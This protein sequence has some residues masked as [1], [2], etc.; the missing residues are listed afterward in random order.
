MQLVFPPPADEQC[1]HT[2]CIVVDIQVSEEVV[3]V[4]V[5]GLRWKVKGKGH[6]VEGIRHEPFK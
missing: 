1:T 5:K 2:I 3:E 4:K 6:R